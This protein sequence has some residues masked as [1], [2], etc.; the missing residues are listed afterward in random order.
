MEGR[1]RPLQQ[2]RPRPGDRPENIGTCIRG[3]ENSHPKPADPDDKPELAAA[4]A[5]DRYHMPCKT[6]LHEESLSLPIRAGPARQETLKRTAPGA[7]Q[8][9]AASRL[10]FVAF[11]ASRP[12]APALRFLKARR[13]SRPLAPVRAFSFA[14]PPLP[15]W[16]AASFFS[17]LLFF[18]L[19]PCRWRSGTAPAA[20]GS[21]RSA[22]PCCDGI[23]L[24][25][26]LRGD[27][28]AVA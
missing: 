6:L 24:S 5:C 27:G 28:K 16:V 26:F 4:L 2:Q 25:V 19:T 1:A 22:A 10:S 8:P 18:S 17:F 21:C 7:M 20:D 15:P 13:W 11:A 23:V 12:T 9:A 3:C 14:N